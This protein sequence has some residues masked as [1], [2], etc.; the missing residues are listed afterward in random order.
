MSPTRALVIG[1]AGHIDHGK[2]ALVEALTGVHPDRLREERERG[3]TIDLG[4][5]HFTSGEATIAIVDVPGHERFVR[6][7]LAG[8]G[9]IDAVMLVVAADESVMPQT[10]EHFDICRLLDVRHGLIVLSKRDL[11]DDAGLARAEAAVRA[12]VAGSFLDS[13]PMIPVSV[14]TGEGLEAL[15]KTLAG[16]A[17]V[18]P[19]QERA[20]L[21]RLPVDRVFSVK[22]FGTVVTGTLVS[23]AIAAGDRLE[24][25]PDR[26]EVRVRAL[27][28]H[29]QTATDVRAPQRVALNLGAVGA[30][31]LIRGTTLATPGSL[32]VAR[33]ADVRLELLPSSPALPH[34]TRVRVHQGTDEAVGR[35]T[36]AAVRAPDGPWVRAVPGDPGVSVPPGG[37]AFVRLRL[38]EALVVTRGDRLVFRAY[39]PASTL[40][41]GVVLDPEPVPGRLRRPQVFDRFVG[42]DGTDFAGVWLTEA[43]AAGLSSE[44]LVRRGGLSR[45]DADTTLEAARVEGRA[46]LLGGRAIDASVIAR[47]EADLLAALAD[48]H[49]KK[50][51]EEGCPREPLRQQVAAGATPDFFAAVVGRLLVA[52]RVVGADRLRLAEH[53]P[54]RGG[55][56]PEAS[57]HLVQ[58]LN[59][60]GLAP[61]D[62]ATLAADSGLGQNDWNDFLRALVREGQVVRL[63]ALLFGGDVLRRFK[64]EIRGLG[65]GAT[66]DVGY[67]KSKYG[68]SRKYAIPLLEWLD[69]ERVTRRVGNSRVVL[70]D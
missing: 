64:E 57:R 3:I 37:Q 58:V 56:W 10:Q 8:V 44:D 2:S 45:A 59:A 55:A 31:D 19:R 61:P 21:A 40:G 49:R 51:R 34:G 68:L 70:P 60:A 9:G 67:V 29:G 47:V 1:T 69:R 46:E 5:A 24:A 50:P 27:Q 28:V 54:E 65:T 48:F 32:P 14:R 23:G 33:R 26:R 7:M 52:G 38:E 41:G 53:E 12:A 4:F 42:L 11:V 43:G 36:V 16:L 15:R 20:G 63:E 13:A 35:V 18:V 17:G 66:I 39:S 30:G 25:L 62:Q 22:G 6:T